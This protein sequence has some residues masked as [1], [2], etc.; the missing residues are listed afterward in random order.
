MAQHFTSKRES[1]PPPV[2]RTL[3]GE[4]WWPNIRYAFL[5]R[6]RWC[7]PLTAALGRQ[8]LADICECEARLVYRACS[9]TGTKQF[10]ET[11]SLKIKKISFIAWNHFLGYC[12]RARQT[13]CPV[14]KSPTS[15]K[16]NLGQV[17]KVQGKPAQFSMA[18]VLISH[19]KKRSNSAFL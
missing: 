10:R 13:P 9:R 7:M 15:W 2:T 1:I 19:L 14:R 6:Y 17:W 11:L 3:P 12:L 18:K 16:Q 5:A 8:R 4:A